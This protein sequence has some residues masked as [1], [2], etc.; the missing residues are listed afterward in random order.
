ML[1]DSV[2]ARHILIA[3]QNQ[4]YAQAKNIADSLAGLLRKGADFEELAKTNSVD[5]NSA[6]NGGDLG[7]FTS[8]TMVQPFSDSA[9]FAKKND[10]KVVLTQYGAHVLQVTDMA[11]PVKKIQIATVEKEVSPSAKTTNQ[12]YNDARTFAIEVSNLDNFNKKV[13]ESGLTNVSLPSAKTI[14]QSPVWRVP[15]K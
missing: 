10:I 7:W 1:P 11:K 9:F 5:Q 6:V 4:D 14:K 3:P 13:E 15:V 12:I 2:R 8:R